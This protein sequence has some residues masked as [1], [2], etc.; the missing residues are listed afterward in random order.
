MMG[1]GSRQLKINI[2]C[3]LVGANN[4]C[5]VEPAIR[6]AYIHLIFFSSTDIIYLT[7]FFLCFG[8][9]KGQCLQLFNRR[10]LIPSKS[11]D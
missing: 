4:M 10:Q 7:N 6:K 2:Y 11:V 1:K 5:D 3:N 9:G 8:E